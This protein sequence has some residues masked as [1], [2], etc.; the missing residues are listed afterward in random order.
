[1]SDERRAMSDEERRE[2]R[3]YSQAYL[4]YKSFS[5]L[6][7]RIKMNNTIA[8]RDAQRKRNLG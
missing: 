2:W 5:E 3:G 4:E 8:P 1:M 7:L 6:K